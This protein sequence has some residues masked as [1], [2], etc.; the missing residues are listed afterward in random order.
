MLGLSRVMSVFRTPH[1]NMSNLECSVLSSRDPWTG[2]FLMHAANSLPM[3]VSF[4]CRVTQSFCSTFFEMTIFQQVASKLFKKFKTKDPKG[5]LCIGVFFL[6]SSTIF[7]MRHFV[8]AIWIPKLNPSD[9]FIIGRTKFKFLRLIYLK[10]A[11]WKNLTA[12]YPPKLASP[13]ACYLLR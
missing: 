4:F 8:Y 12:R 13:C 1:Q 7:P 5:Q 6:I 2:S 3:W 9:Y 10:G 11:Q